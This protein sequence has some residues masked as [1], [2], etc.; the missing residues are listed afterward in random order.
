MAMATGITAL[1]GAVHLVMADREEIGRQRV[2]PLITVGKPA[3]PT[4]DAGIPDPGA[5]GRGDHQSP[6]PR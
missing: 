2:I 5:R 1:A 3:S 4:P 6:G